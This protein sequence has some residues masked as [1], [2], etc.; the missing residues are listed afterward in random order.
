MQEDKK[1]RT[2]HTLD[3]ISVQPLNGRFT[4]QIA[5]CDLASGSLELS[6]CMIKLMFIDIVGARQG[7][8]RLLFPRNGIHTLSQKVFK[9]G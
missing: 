4:D 8:A 3:I 2:L 7:F 5:R 6:E 1:I 9:Q